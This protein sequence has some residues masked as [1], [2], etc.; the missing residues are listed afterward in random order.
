MYDL[1]RRGG[2]VPSSVSGSGFFVV[3][4]EVGRISIPVN[5]ITG[6]L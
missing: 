5:M 1:R 3:A 2:S 4:P 6:F